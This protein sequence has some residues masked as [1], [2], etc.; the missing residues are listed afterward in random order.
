M[1]DDRSVSDAAQRRYFAVDFGIDYLII[2]RD[3]SHVMEILR[4]A[5][6]DFNEDLAE[7]GGPVIRE[8]ERGQS[9]QIMI[10]D[11][12]ELCNLTEFPMGSYFSSEF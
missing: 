11:D 8:L 1:S 5:D 3:D 9:A 7:F 4:E 10:W 6:F 12:S 2:A